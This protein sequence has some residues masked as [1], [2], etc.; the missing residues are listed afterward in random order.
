MSGSEE[1][2]SKLL[3]IAATLAGLKA[4]ESPAFP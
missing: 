2:I 1:A 4:G 3:G